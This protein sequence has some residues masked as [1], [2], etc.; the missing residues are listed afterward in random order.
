M[1]TPSLSG[2]EGAESE[3]EQ[4]GE[5]KLLVS[6][7]SLEEVSQYRNSVLANYLSQY[8]G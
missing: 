7:K 4:E 3:E 6:G 2:E 1:E 5:L 8:R